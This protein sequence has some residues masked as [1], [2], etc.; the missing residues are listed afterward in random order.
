MSRS[1]ALA[2]VLA[3]LVLAGLTL[4]AC[5]HS[6]H[7]DPSSKLAEEATT[8]T[9]LYKL[10]AEEQADQILLAVHAQGLS[11]AQDEAVR[12][13][14]ARWREGGARSIEISAPQG[15]DAAAVYRMA[16]VVRDRLIAEGVPVAAVQQ[17]AYDAGGDPKAPLKVSFTRFQAVIP[18]C[19]KS[20]ENLTA[21]KDNEVQS[22]FGC[23]VTA[24][25]AA[26]IADPADIAG[27]HPS[28]SADA[29][30]R[31][32]VIQAYRK[33]EVTSGATDTKASG[34]VSN[35]VGGTQ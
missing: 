8:P 13:L 31:I 27:P 21:T 23:A 14:A 10:H 16:Q 1:S 29:G 7:S 15:V 33:G 6:Q 28:G 35:A 2:P 5:A 19:G 9:E 17:L 22:N 26:M 3:A 34:V 12:Q 32:A 4:G 24:N 20:W 18:A 25:M 30:R 11:A